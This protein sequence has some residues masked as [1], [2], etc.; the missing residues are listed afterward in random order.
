MNIA[1]AEIVTGMP[2]EKL[3]KIKQIN[4]NTGDRTEFM[5]TEAKEDVTTYKGKTRRGKG[6]QQ[7]L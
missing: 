3:T 7:G 6:K 1:E 5:L 4:K 2:N